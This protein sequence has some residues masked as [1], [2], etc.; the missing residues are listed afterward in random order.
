MAGDHGRWNEYARGDYDHPYGDV[1]DIDK[2]PS[3]MV[4]YGILN[5]LYEY[6]KRNISNSYMEE[7]WQVGMKTSGYHQ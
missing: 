1:G 4:N 3:T 7:K 5:D 2:K 6:W